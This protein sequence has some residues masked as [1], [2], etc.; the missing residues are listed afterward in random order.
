MFDGFVLSV[1]LLFFLLHPALLLLHVAPALFDLFV[2]FCPDLEHFFPGLYH[3]FALFGLSSLDGVVENARCLFFGT[4][5]LFFCN[6]FPV[7]ET[8]HKSD[9]TNQNKQNR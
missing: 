6:F 8:G 1:Q 3:S 9:D 7:C 4:A 5:N 2:G